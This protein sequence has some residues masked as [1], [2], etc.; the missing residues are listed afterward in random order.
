MVNREYRNIGEVASVP[1]LFKKKGGLKV[2]SQPAGAPTFAGKFDARIT[3]MQSSKELYLKFLCAAQAKDVETLRRIIRE[4]PEL[5][6]Y[7]GNDGS[8][9]DVIY[10]NC[11]E[12]VDAAFQA[13]LSPDCGPK[14]RHEIFLQ[15]AAPTMTRNLF[16]WLCAMVP[17]LS[18]E[19]SRRKRRWD[20]LPH[21][22]LSL[23]FGCW[24]RR[25]LT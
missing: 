13:G 20:T 9:L 6:D 25:A 24:L 3:G 10:H 4:H 16:A 15:R 2:Q 5:H 12:H 22:L 17:I 21:G 7:G 8:L 14:E 18:G 19:I 1:I 11:P 23:S